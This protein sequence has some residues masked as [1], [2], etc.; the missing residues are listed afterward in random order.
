MPIDTRKKEIDDLV[1]HVER[2]DWRGLRKAY[3]AAAGD[4]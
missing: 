4:S 1:T 3:Y 2:M